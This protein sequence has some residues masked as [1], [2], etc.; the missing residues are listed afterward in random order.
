MRNSKD[1]GDETESRALSKLI[2]SGYSVSIPFGD[3][4]RYDLVVDDGGDLYRLQCKTGWPNK[5]ETMRFNTHSQ[6]TKDGVY[7]ERTYHGA[8]DAF[9]VYYPEMETFYWIDTAEATDQKM[10]LRFESE[11]S[12]PSINWAEAYEFDG[13]IP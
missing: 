11:I 6:T 1:I 9:L 7:H 8:I 5:D 2:E 10:E 13:K 12:H 3:N 4:D